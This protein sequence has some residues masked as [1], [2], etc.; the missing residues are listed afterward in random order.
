MPDF[1]PRRLGPAGAT[2]VGARRF[3]IAYNVTLATDRLEVADAIARA[4]RA[5]SG[6][7]PAVQARAFPT[8]LPEVV[9]VSVNLL[10]TDV[11]PLHAV[12]ARILAEAERWQVELIASELV[13]MLPTAVLA[14]TVMH[15][16]RFARL[17][18]HSVVEARLLESVFASP[19]R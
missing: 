1:G 7:L 16:L 10:D 11:T 6:G 14:D 5:S 3:L 13:G 4:I 2:A 18:A 15:E 8:A 12:F 19:A 17:D 9:Q